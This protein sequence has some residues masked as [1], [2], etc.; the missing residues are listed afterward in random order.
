MKLRAEYSIKNLI[1]FGNYLLSDARKEDYARNP[2]FPKKELLNERLSSVND[3]DLSKFNISIRK[4]Y[5]PK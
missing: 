1:D 3:A 2:N 4:A 5:L